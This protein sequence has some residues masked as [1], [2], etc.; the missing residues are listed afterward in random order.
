MNA[1]TS[2]EEQINAAIKTVLEVLPDDH[3]LGMHIAAMHANG[4]SSLSATPHTSVSDDPLTGCASMGDGQAW[5]GRTWRRGGIP[6]WDDDLHGKR[7][8]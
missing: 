1:V 7:R 2:S 3:P 5:E 4:A 8:R 6:E